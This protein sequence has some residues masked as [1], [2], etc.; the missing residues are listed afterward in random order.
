MNLEAIVAEVLARTMRVDKTDE[1][2]KSVRKAIRM[3][4]T[5][6]Y[7]P[8][9]IVEEEVDLGGTYQ[10]FKIQLPPRVRK[11]TNVAPLNS[12]GDPVPITTKN[13]TFEYVNA[14]DIITSHHERKSDIYYVT[15]GT[16]TVKSTVGAQKLYVGF[17]ALPEISDNQLETW[18]MR[19]YESVFIDAALA[20]F[21]S[22][23]G[24]TQQARTKRDDMLVQLQGLIDDYV[25]MEE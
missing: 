14:Q 7:F 8:R 2:R 1:I 11:F 24:R 18:L 23:I 9:D 15:G 5:A 22:S 19:D 16:L 10:K 21:Y 3:V 4:H 12:N 6:A 17:Y 13:N 25:E 20:D